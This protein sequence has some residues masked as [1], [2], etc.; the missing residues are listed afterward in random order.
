MRK[1]RP[2]TAVLLAL[3]SGAARAAVKEPEAAAGAAEP[4]ARPDYCANFAD[5]AA[6]AR[7]AW[8]KLELQALEQQLD[9][10]IR[11]LDEKRGE[12][13]AWRQ[14]RDAETRQAGQGLVDIFAKMRPDA[15]AAQLA[16]LDIKTAAAI[17]RQ[18]SARNA[19]AILNE[20]Q[21]GSA[22]ELTRI[23]AQAG[24][25]KPEAVSP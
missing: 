14:V 2:A 16:L 20:M 3:L 4:R 5:A 13:L 25:G 11:L 1:W 7:V 17:L 15:A 18:L 24:P 19:S 8:L 21:G 6:E 12:Y 10:K 23:L 22:A 9:A